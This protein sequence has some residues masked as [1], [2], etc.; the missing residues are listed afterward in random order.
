MPI[1]DDPNSFAF[2]T[3]R[4]DRAKPDPLRFKVM[5]LTVAQS[6]SLTSLRDEA[7]K[8]ATQDEIV[9][10]M[11]ATIV[12]PFIVGWT[13][14]AAFTVETLLSRL[15]AMEIVEL[16]CGLHTASL[17]TEGDLKNSGLPASSGQA[18]SAISAAP[19]ASTPPP[20]PSPDAS[21]VSIATDAAAP[22]AAGAAGLQ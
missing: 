16:A 3:L 22:S 8:K 7:F 13:D 6:R 9:D 19:A 4:V 5:A 18:S 10:A 14:P 21:T 2:Y 17:P 12:M 11:L 20:P 1:C 15:H